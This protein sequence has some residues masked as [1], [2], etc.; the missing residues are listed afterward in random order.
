VLVMAQGRLLRSSSLAALRTEAGVGSKVLTP[1][2]DR[3]TSALDRAGIS[4]RRR[5]VG[6]A[7]DAT[8][9]QVGELAAQH[10]IVLHGLEG[11]ADLEKAFFRLTQ[12]PHPPVE[13]PLS[14]EGAL[15]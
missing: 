2:L 3:L 10:R 4:H 13:R 7:V 12:G 6:L 5:D 15:S 9:E 14:A 8:P 11:T 1:H